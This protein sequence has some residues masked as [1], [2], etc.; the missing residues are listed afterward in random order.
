M[1][2]PNSCQSPAVCFISA[3]YAEQLPLDAVD[4]GVANIVGSAHLALVC[5]VEVV[6][7]QHD[8]RESKDVWVIRI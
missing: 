1:Y 7:V 8:H 6:R 4:P 2:Y 5:F 3:T